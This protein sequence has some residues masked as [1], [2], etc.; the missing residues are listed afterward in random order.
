M[1]NLSFFLLLLLLKICVHIKLEGFIVNRAVRW[2]C[3]QSILSPPSLS[4]ATPL[5]YIFR[6]STFHDFSNWNN[7]Q[8]CWLSSLYRTP[9][10]K[11]MLSLPPLKKVHL[12]FR[13]KKKDWD[14]LQQTRSILEFIY[15]FLW[16][17]A[18]TKPFFSSRKQWS[19]QAFPGY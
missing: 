17:L 12:Q 4:S 3:K 5:L 13:Y 2:V 6:H 10:N 16:N 8:P 1:A 9:S 11:H 14:Y 15:T 19:A 18:A 7:S